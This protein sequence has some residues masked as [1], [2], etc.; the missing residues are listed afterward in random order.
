MPTKGK[1]LLQLAVPTKIQGGINAT[2][3]KAA[4]MPSTTMM[5]EKLRKKDGPK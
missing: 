3:K 5:T 2:E 1:P 4:T